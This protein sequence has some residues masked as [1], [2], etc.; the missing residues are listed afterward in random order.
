VNAAGV[1]RDDI[2]AARRQR[3]SPRRE[4]RLRGVHETRALSRVD[5]RRGVRELPAAPR[6]HFD[7]YQRAAFI[8][9]H[10][11]D[12]A[13]AARHVAR[14]ETHALPLQEIERARL[15]RIAERFGHG[16]SLKVVDGQA[17][18]RVAK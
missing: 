17:N 9:H 16:F 6:P 13:A 1:E 7:E 11:I 4:E 5:A 15:E 10:E 2:E 14:D 8:G 3:A 18:A 12:L